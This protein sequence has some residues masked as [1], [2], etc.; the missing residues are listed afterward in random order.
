MLPE[1]QSRGSV[2]LPHG[3]W[4]D[5]EDLLLRSLQESRSRLTLQRALIRLL[6][7]PAVSAWDVMAVPVLRGLTWIM[8]TVNAFGVL[9]AAE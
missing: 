8:C 3:E 9:G 7:H 4:F 1:I 5:M 6:T 2:T